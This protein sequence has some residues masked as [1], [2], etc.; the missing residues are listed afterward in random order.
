M[1]ELS[2]EAQQPEFQTEE[3]LHHPQSAR[4]ERGAACQKEGS[5]VLQLST[6]QTLQLDSGFQQFTCQHMSSL[7][8]TSLEV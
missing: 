4:R 5:T 7:Q 6:S 2:A 8:S 3:S 1:L